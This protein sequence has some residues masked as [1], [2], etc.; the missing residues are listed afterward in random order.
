MP[1]FQPKCHPSH[2]VLVFQGTYPLKKESHGMPGNAGDG[3]MSSYLLNN[4]G[5]GGGHH[6]RS[7]LN[8]DVLP[9]GLGGGG[10][11]FDRDLTSS[12]GGMH[13]RG[14]PVMGVGKSLLSINK[15]GRVGRKR[16]PKGIALIALFK[17]KNSLLS[18]ILNINLSTFLNSIIELVD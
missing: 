7:L 3:G 12:F 5:L 9:G 17:K 2:V 13:G 18:T 14:G 1:F 6:P 8:P 11:D 10:D 15:D 4:P 16:G